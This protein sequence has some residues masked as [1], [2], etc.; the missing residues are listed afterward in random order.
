LSFLFVFLLTVKW[1]PLILV[2]VWKLL[3]F[4]DA[5]VKQEDFIFSDVNQFLASN[6]IDDI[7]RS[8]CFCGKM[9]S[10]RL[11]PNDPTPEFIYESLFRVMNNKSLFFPMSR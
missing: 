10:R 5:Q 11:N 3:V 9:F 1:W 7:G 8:E 4:I 6:S 2:S